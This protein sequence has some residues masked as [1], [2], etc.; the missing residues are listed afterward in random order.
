MGDTQYVQ[1]MST[2]L[3]NA[4]RWISEVV[5]EHPEKKRNQVVKEAELRFDLT[6]RECDFLD[7]NFTE[8]I[9]S[10]TC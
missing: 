2:N 9:S 8:L 6:P 5:Q 10:S 4:V 1:G 3:K 7:K